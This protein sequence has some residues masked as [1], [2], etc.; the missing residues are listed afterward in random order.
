LYRLHQARASFVTRAKSPMD[1]RRVY[2]AATNRVTGVLCDQRV[3][4]NGFYSAK[5]YPEHLR[6]VQESVASRAVLQTDQAASSDQT[7]PGQQRERGEDAGVV[8][9][10]HNHRLLG[11]NSVHGIVLPSRRRRHG[12]DGVEHTDGTV[13]A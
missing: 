12:Q 5:K 7:F 6:A 11:R 9:R 10:R 2:S 8:R 13:D 1:A 4:L 3:M